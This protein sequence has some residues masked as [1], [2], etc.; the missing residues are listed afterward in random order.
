MPSLK[1]PD[2]FS[3]RSFLAYVFTATLVLL[4]ALIGAIGTGHMGV[5]TIRSL[6]DREPSVTLLRADPQCNAAATTCT[7]GDGVMTI[8]FS[9]QGEVSPLRRMQMIVTLEGETAVAVEQV[10]VRFTMPRMNMGLNRFGLAPAGDGRWRGEAMLA[11]CVTGR[12]DWLARVEVRGH[13][14]YAAEFSV[15]LNP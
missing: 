10:A 9:L 7:A 2:K 4:G 12:Q 14:A 5:D 3:P 15:E 13:D 11:V 1:S 8:G 6:R